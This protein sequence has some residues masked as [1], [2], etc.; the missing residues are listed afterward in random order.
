VDRGRQSARS[1]RLERIAKAA[2]GFAGRKQTARHSAL[3]ES[4][5]SLQSLR[6]EG[7]RDGIRAD[8][9]GGEHRRD[10]LLFARRRL[11]LRQI[12]QAGGRGEES[13]ARRSAEALSRRAR[14]A[15]LE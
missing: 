8:L 5:A 1:R 2:E 14:D 9:P 13:G 4:A 7:I 6:P 12:P 11:S 10:Q 15:Y 3:R